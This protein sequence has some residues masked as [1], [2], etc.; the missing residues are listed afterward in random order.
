MKSRV[1]W[2][3][4]GF[5]L[6]IA[7]LALLIGG[8]AS[9]SWRELRELHKQF[10]NSQLRSFEI[11]DHLQAT[12]LRLNNSIVAYQLRGDPADVEEFQR[13]SRRLNEWIDEK[14]PDLSS[15][16][17][18]KLLDQIDTAYDDY[19]ETGNRVIASLQTNG[20]TR[21]VANIEKIINASLVMLELGYHL[22]DAHRNSLEASLATSQQS[23][24]LL[25]SVIF[26]A[27]FLLVALGLW[28]AM[29]IYRDMLRPLRTQLG[30]SRAIIERQEKL[31]SLGL[32][33]AGVAHEIRN[34]LTAIKARL[35]ILQ[36]QFGPGTSEQAEGAFISQEIHRLERI[37]RD[38]LEFARPSEPQFEELGAAE[39]LRDAGTLLAP[40]LDK[41]RVCL[42]LANA[43]DLKLRGDRQQLKQV[44]INL[45]QN[46][47]D[48]ID[49]GGDVA[50]SARA[51]NAVLGGQLRPAVI[52]EVADSGKGIPREVE[53]RIFD[54]FF[55]T[56]EKGTGLGLSIAARI[57]EK[58]GGM[59]EY[60]T[61]MNRGTIFS[62]ILPQAQPH[63]KD[64]AHP[65]D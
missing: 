53:E 28:L 23:I 54:P 15:P 37:L 36:K 64:R 56:K 59:L 18:R 41:R 10:S 51:A 43:P 65:V 11:A 17:E 32:L 5:S 26:G 14:K 13:A 61:Q 52:L 4:V 20:T 19:M 38:F 3:V 22:E 24:S 55:T 7:S 50:L 60:Q 42:R 48:S 27:L 31:A 35:F 44:L 58:H 62:V 12:I 47:A 40:E 8:A 57:V 39:V 16:Q 34:P 49:A 2:R 33:A 1:K 30:E 46:A 6:A 25:Q 21:S 9:A 45:I 63:E 29:V